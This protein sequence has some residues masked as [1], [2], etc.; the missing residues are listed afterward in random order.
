VRIGDRDRIV[1]S[2]TA[3]QVNHDHGYQ[4]LEYT[5][6]SQGHDHQPRAKVPSP[7]GPSHARGL[8]RVNDVRE[9]RHDSDINMTGTLAGD[10]TWGI[11]NRKRR[12]GWERAE[13]LRWENLCA[14]ARSLYSG[15]LV[16]LDRVRCCGGRCV[17]SIGLR[18]DEACL[19]ITKQGRA[20]SI[21]EKKVVKKMRI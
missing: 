13:G 11:I 15:W 19:D 17:G 2:Y 6:C 20:A 4:D 9:I 5:G 8:Q 18:I 21:H 10:S 12:M 3:R 16:N 14:A 7:S 1:Q